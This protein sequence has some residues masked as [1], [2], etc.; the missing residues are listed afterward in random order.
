MNFTNPARLALSSRLLALLAV[1]LA[2]L[3]ATG[4]ILGQ[5]ATPE[6]TAEPTEVTIT[7]AQGETVVPFN[8]QTV[9]TFDLA[10]L[11][12]LETLGIAVAGVPKSN[13]P[14][15]LEHFAGEEF[16]D[17]GTLF[18]P[19]YEVVAAANP[20]LIIVS[21]R[22]A[23]VYPE[24]SAIAPTIDLTVDASD[25]L[26]SQQRNAEIIGQ[27]FGLED[28]VEELWTAIDEDV[29]AVQEL[30]A[31]AGTALIV[32]TSGGEVNAYGLGSR[33]GWIHDTLG[34]TPVV[35]D[36]EAAT[37]G[38]AISFEF[39]LET[40]PDWLI[41][42]DRDAAVGEQ[43]EAAAQILDNELV[44]QTTAW[45]NDQVIYLDPVDWYLIAGGLTTLDRMVDA[46]GTSLTAE[47]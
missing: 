22:S 2:L 10:T 32:M 46:I 31:E 36:V 1:L 21:A 5:E 9:L 18:E 27:I 13:L 41:V 44:A 7:H 29:T 39:I 16:L 26:G 33:F 24:L 23:A 19:D 35:E 15:R 40:N 14:G 42:L 4:V 38:E 47:E 3:G 20:D 34:F 11:D 12:T 30:T 43:A 28:E 8:P 45:S 37:H 17:I 6:A 25:F